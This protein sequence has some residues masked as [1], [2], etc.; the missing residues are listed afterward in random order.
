MTAI[1]ILNW[2]GADDTL[3]C[4]QS[5]EK[6]QGDFF[7]IVADNGST[8]D[9][10][11]RINDFVRDYPHEIHILEHGQNYGFAA[12]NNRAIAFASQFK[13]DSY[14][15][16]NN[17]TEVTPDFL[18]IL[19]DFR[20]KNEAYRVLTP[21]INFYYDKERIWNCGGRLFL[22][23]RKYLFAGKKESEATKRRFYRISFVT[24]CALFFTPDIL[25]SDGK[26]L[27]ERFFF[28]EE[29]FEFSIRMKRSCTKMACVTD[30]VIYHKVGAANAK[31]NIPGKI[32][33]HLLNRY[34]DIRL[35]YGRLFSFM[36]RLCNKPLSFH[37]LKREYGSVGQALSKL[38]RLE[39]ESRS[40]N[41]VT[42]QDFRRLVILGNYFYET[43]I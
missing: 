14:L 21:R 23:F 35:Q 28:G 17:D 39:K 20:R 40:K 29:D 1:I 5:L 16:L 9:S 15:L 32:Y 12:G 2:N 18:T 33:L 31:N 30:S 22:G 11:R 4:L 36:W 7:V 26:L 42:E 3:A 38:R 6:A 41:E 25:T 37:H 13:P 10:V 8:D 34:I 24:G 43:D 27:T 19:E